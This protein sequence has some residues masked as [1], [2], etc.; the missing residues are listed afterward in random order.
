[1]SP[2]TTGKCRCYPGVG[3]VGLAASWTLLGLVPVALPDLTYPWLAMGGAGGVWLWLERRRLLRLPPVGVERLVNGVLPVGVWTAVS[4]RFHN[5][6]ARPVRLRVFDHY[7]QPGEVRHQPRQ[8][9]VDGYSWAEC[10]YQLRPLERGTLAFGP[11]QVVMQATGDTWRRD[12]LLGPPQ[13]VKVYPN[14][15]LIARYAALAADRRTAV[16]GVHKQRRRGEGR[17]F[18]QLRD[19]RVGDSLRQIDWK[20]TARLRRPIAKDYQDERHQTL[21]FVLDTSRRMRTRD[22][23]LSHFDHALDAVILLAFVALSQG[24][25][26]GILSFGGSRR[27]IAPQT[28]KQSLT[29][30]INAVYDLQPSLASPDYEAAAK[31]LLQHQRKRC[32]VVLVTN[33]RDED[34]FEAANALHLLARRHLVLLANLREVVLDQLLHQPIAD[35][36]QAV[37]YAMVCQYLEARERCQRQVQHRGGLVVDVPPHQLP[38]ALVNGYWEVKTSRR[39]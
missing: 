16:L 23:E 36:D 9:V 6:S 2:S 7:P 38:I 21:L 25:S 24:D 39:L 15:A 27:W 29:T 11:V 12:G 4:L 14:F 10:H 18:F 5:L 20:A 37:L 19:Y 13:Q 8:L 31:A 3:S 26:V 33:L 17:D 28:G 1:M 30:L 32:L 34:G 35:L 22:G